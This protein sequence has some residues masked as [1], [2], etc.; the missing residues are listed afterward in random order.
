MIHLS[1]HETSGP[2]TLHVLHARISTWEYQEL[3]QIHLPALRAPG[4]ADLAATAGH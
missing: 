3:S 2:G 4:E 1:H